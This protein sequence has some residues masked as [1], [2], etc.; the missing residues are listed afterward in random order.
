MWYKVSQGRIIKYLRVVVRHMES[1]E[2]NIYD[3]EYHVGHVSLIIKA[4]IRGFERVCDV[5][6]ARSVII[7]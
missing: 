5:C 3:T 7:M 2:F 6:V 4:L 1:L